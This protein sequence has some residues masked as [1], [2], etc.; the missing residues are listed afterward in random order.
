MPYYEVVLEGRQGGKDM[1][2][3]FHYET[4]GGEPMDWQAAADVIAGHVFDH[5]VPLCGPR[6]TWIGITY[7]ED[8]PGG[9]GVFVPFGAGALTGSSVF[10]DQADVLTMLVRKL[11][12]STQR[13]THG[14]WQQGGLSADHTTNDGEWDLG[15][16]NG[17]VN[18]GN[19][20]RSLEIAGSANL[21]MVI[22]ASNPTAPN[23]VPYNQV[24]SITTSGVPRTQ[25]SRLPDAG[26]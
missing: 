25:R 8:I 14:W 2:T 13:P 26:S 1:L 20:M 9:V 4:I 12:G 3:V 24:S 15:V 19:E 7:R 11:T 5:L 17:I 21:Q 23:T 6:V 16:R 22:K 18:Y 10:G